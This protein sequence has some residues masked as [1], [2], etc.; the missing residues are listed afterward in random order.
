MG[1]DVYVRPR[2]IDSVQNSANVE[3]P[4]IAGPKG[5]ARA[6]PG[7]APTIPGVLHP[8]T[9]TAGETA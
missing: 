5:L 6:A 4:P 9:I 1:Q 3:L 2:A 8:P 7:G